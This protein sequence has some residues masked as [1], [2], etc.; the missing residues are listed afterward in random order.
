MG[1]IMGRSFLGFVM[2]TRAG[3]SRILSRNMRREERVSAD[4]TIPAPASRR[5][6]F[7]SRGAEGKRP[8]GSELKAHL[9][10][11]RLGNRVERCALNFDKTV[12]YEDA[13]PANLASVLWV[14]R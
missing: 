11:R 1:L 14:G 9:S 2:F 8:Y 5:F 4:L 12:P 10:K 3:A 7:G 13:R 6:G